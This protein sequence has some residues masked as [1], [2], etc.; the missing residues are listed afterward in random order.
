MDNDNKLLDNKVVLR[1]DE[2]AQILRISKTNVYKLVRQKKIVGKK[3]GG[4]IRIATMSI[5]KYI[6]E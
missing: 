2:V 1:P 5:K 6:E 3:I 4:S